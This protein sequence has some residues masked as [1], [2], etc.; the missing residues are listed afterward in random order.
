LIE[1]IRSTLGMSAQQLPAAAVTAFVRSESQQRALLCGYQA[2]I[3]KPV[4]PT[5]LT[6]TVFELAHGLLGSVAHQAGRPGQQQLDSLCDGRTDD[7][8]AIDNRAVSP[9]RRRLRVLFVEDNADLREQIGWML[10][11]EMIDPVICASGEEA[12]VEFA[13]GGF[14]AVMTDISLPNMTG[15]ELARRVLAQAPQAWVIFSTGYALEEGLREFGP[16]VR[17]LLKPFEMEELR[18]LLDEVRAGL[19]RLAR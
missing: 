11:E 8:R 13:K 3:L 6:R 9:Q 19:D 17:S 16:N 4:D 2:C 5:V 10:Q 14:D 7:V 18:R 1:N 12:E 15:I